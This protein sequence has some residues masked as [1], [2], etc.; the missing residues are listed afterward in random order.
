MYIALARIEE[1]L[2]DIERDNLRKAYIATRPKFLE[3]A[4]AIHAVPDFWST[5]IDE[6]P[7]EIDQRIQPRDV[8]ALNCLTGIDVERFEVQDA[9]RGEPRSIKLTFSFK[10]NQWFHDEQ[11]EKRFFWRMSKNGWSGL[12]S[13]PVGIQWKERDLTD[14]LL[15]TAVKLWKQEQEFEVRNVLHL[16]VRDANP[17]LRSKQANGQDRDAI[18]A[19][20]E[21][22][23]LV[24]KVQRTPQDAISI[25]GL[26]GFRGHQISAEESTKAMKRKQDM[27]GGVEQW[28]ELDGESPPLPDIE[29]Y[30]HGEEVAVAFS[31]DLYPGATQYFTAAKER[32]AKMSDEEPV[33]GPGRS[34]ESDETDE[35]ER[36]QRPKKKNKISSAM[37]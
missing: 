6:A 32:D 20:D 10:S 15:D 29:I 1:Q 13:E 11:I 27:V 37:D 36:E 19:T 23:T 8:P 31:E 7:A 26:F 3:R 34:E 16:R 22:K 9:E 18:G 33:S 17:A 2:A 30:P 28:E 5:V 4:T 24:E 14:G 25:F 21:F 35:G 12:V